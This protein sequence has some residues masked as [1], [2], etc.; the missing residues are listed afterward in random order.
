MILCLLSLLNLG[1]SVAFGAIISLPGLGLCIS[2][3]IPITL[4]TIRKLKGQHPRYGP[5]KLGRWGLPI[6]LFAICICTWCL[7]F[8]PFPSFY[9]VTSD[10]LNYAGPITLGVIMLCLV[11]LEFLRRI[12]TILSF[13]MRKSKKRGQARHGGIRAAFEDA[14]QSRKIKLILPCFGIKSV[15]ISSTL[16]QKTMTSQIGNQ[17]PS[18]PQQ[19]QWRASS[20]HAAL[21]ELS[22]KY[23]DRN[24][25][26]SILG[27][28]E[29]SYA[30]VTCTTLIPALSECSWQSPLTR[31]IGQ[32]VHNR[33]NFS[34]VE[35]A[36]VELRLM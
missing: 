36:K 26:F 4:L 16:F 23:C 14:S 18:A 12:S 31:T 27:S 9:P 17:W 7:W 6:N 32:F 3:L 21:H 8:I 5:F 11:D 35:D 34:S 13:M 20:S 1:S 15:P 10:N 25:S 29:A 19:L 33:H 24:H 30:V 28:D 22:T 2:Y